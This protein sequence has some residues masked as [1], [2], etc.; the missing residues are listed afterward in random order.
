[1]AN[2][3]LFHK[4][5]SG[6][7]N[8]LFMLIQKNTTLNKAV[9]AIDPNDATMKKLLDEIK[10]G[11]FL[12]DSFSDKNCD[13][14]LLRL[15]KD[16]KISY[17][18]FFTAYTYL[19]ALIET[20]NVDYK[21]EDL[22]TTKDVRPVEVFNLWDDKKNQLSKEGEKYIKELCHVYANMRDFFSSAVK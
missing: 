6:T 12:P 5:E 21:Y 10:Q 16:N 3:R 13:I 20:R 19:M 1:M 17:P 9:D 18:I 14:Y 8:S 2:Q 4:L 15:F 7:Y 11:V 22:V